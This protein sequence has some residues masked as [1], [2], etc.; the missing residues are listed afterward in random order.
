MDRPG[1]VARGWAIARLLVAVVVAAAVI[2]QGFSTIGSA[3]EEGRHVATTAANYFSFFTILSNIAAALVLAGAGLR[4]FRR[5]GTDAP[6]PAALAIAFLCVTT[7]LVTTGV[8]YNILLR[9][10]SIGPDTVG[11]ANEVVHVGAPLYLLADLLF[12]PR[13][14]AL[15]WRAAFAA[16]VFPLAWIAYTLVRAPIITA[17]HSGTP[18]WY[19]YPFLDPHEGGWSSVTAYIVAIALG[20]VAVAVGVVAVLRVR[21]RRAG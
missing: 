8:V 21:A 17:P 13:H 9:A 5:R 7:Y 10:I 12:G 20:I 3:A 14:P 11:W 4:V 16:V 15:R 18:Y 19:P 1:G 2:A 6:E